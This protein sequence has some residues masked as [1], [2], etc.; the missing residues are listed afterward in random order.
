MVTF[1]LYF[2]LYRTLKRPWAQPWMSCVSSKGKILWNKLPMLSWTLLNQWRTRKLVRS[3]LNLPVPFIPSWSETLMPLW[4]GA[5]AQPLKWWRHLNLL[6]QPGLQELSWG[7]RPCV[8][9]DLLSS[10]DQVAVAAQ[11]WGVLRWHPQ[12]SSFLTVL[13]INLAQC[14]SRSHKRRILWEND[15]S[16][17][18]SFLLRRKQYDCTNDILRRKDR[19]NVT[20]VKKK[21]IFGIVEVV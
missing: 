20:L 19:E 15:G 18:S 1:C 21:T 8:P 13:Q 5:A 16:F 14:S 9:S 6:S 3:I 4:D 2:C 7:P 10:I 17:W 12:R 11:E